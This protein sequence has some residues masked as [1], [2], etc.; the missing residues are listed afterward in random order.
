MLLDGGPVGQPK[1]PHFSAALWTGT[2]AAA[3]AMRFFATQEPQAKANFIK[4]LDG[5]LKLQE[6]TSDWKQF[7]RA[8][9]PAKGNPTGGWRA[10]TGAYAGLEWLEGGNNDMMKGLYLAYIFG[11]QLL[12]QGV[13]GHEDLCT[14]IRRNARHLSD[15][16]NVDRGSD[17]LDSAWL[18]A[19][20]SPALDAISYRAKA[21]ATWTAQKAVIKATPATYTQGIADWSGL[22]LGFASNLFH[23]LLAERLDL[24]GDAKAAYTGLVADGFDALSEQRLPLWNLLQGAFPKGAANAAAIADAKARLQE[25]PFPKPM[26]VVDLRV[27]PWFC[28]SPYPSL[29]WK[30]DWTTTDRTQSLRTVPLYMAPLDLYAFRVNMQYKGG[31][32]DVKAPAPEYLIAYWFGRRYGLISAND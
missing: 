27:N 6:V 20:V 32:A 29:P 5:V 2:Y 24:G 9:R 15:D 31:S 26:H 3:Q 12:C 4:V 21:E 17:E 30:N 10:G 8:I 7:A 28:M 16:I 18:T 1:E 25:M 19:V 22:N 23:L 13:T 14:R 11:H